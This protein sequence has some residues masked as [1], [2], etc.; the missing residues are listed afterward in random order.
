MFGRKIH[1]SLAEIG[2]DPDLAVF[3]IPAKGVPDGVEACGNTGIRRCVV[4]CGGFSEFA[5]E[6]STLET[7][8]ISIAE[9]NEIRFVGPNCVGILNLENGM[10]LPFVPLYP[11]KV[12][13]GNVSVL[14][15]SGGVV[16]D[17]TRLF[18]LENIG[19]SKMVS[20]G[21]KLN[22]NETDLLE[23]LVDDPATKIIVLHLES[24]SNGAKAAGYSSPDF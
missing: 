8:L 12:K 13:K 23:Y 17:F 18:E 22:V 5:D 2:C 3:L 21:N 11:S 16:M 1:K 10:V 9:R 7:E 4:Q 15:Q 19:F 24:V 14:A 6:N 20:M